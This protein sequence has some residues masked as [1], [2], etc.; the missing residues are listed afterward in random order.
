MSVPVR[1]IVSLQ[2]SRTMKRKKIFSGVDSENAVV[3]N[4]TH[5]GGKD[6]REI[7][8]RGSKHDPERLSPWW[9]SAG[10][11]GTNCALVR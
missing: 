3:P 5:S 9:G 1:L 7:E 6:H 2:V 11:I 10:L 8:P 4:R